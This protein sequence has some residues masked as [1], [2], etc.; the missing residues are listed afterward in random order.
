MLAILAITCPIFALIGLGFICV[1]LGAFART[2]MG[3]LGRFVIDIALP[4]L[5]LSSLSRRGLAEILRLDYLAA[6]AGAAF[7]A[8]ALAL[9]LGLRRHGLRESAI[10]AMGAA[11]SNTAFMGFAIVSQVAPSAASL[12]LALNLLVEN[13]LVLPFALALA[14]LGG[15]AGQNGPRD[16]AGRLGTTAAALGRKPFIIAILAGLALSILGMRPPEPVLRALDMLGAVAAPAALFAIG[17]NL[18]GGRPARS[19]RERLADMGLIA[20]VKLVLHPLLAAALVCGLPALPPEMRMAAVAFAAMPVFALY[21][22][23][24]MS[25]G[26]ERFCSAVVVLATL[27]SFATITVALWLARLFVMP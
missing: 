19:E 25:Y 3:V 24:G 4:A 17:G 11:V 5:L 21:P 14:D 12:T 8:Y 15:Q 13:V 26:M 9:G 22:M 10:L 20:G 7:C 18:A 27:C 2:D 6:C 23:F 1:R 16:I